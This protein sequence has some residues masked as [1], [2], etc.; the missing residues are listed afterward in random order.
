MASLKRDSSGNHVVCFR[1]GGREGAFVTVAGL[2][3]FL[4]DVR[5]RPL[6]ENERHE[7]EE[8]A[9]PVQPAAGS[10]RVKTC[11]RNGRS[12]RV[13]P[14][15]SSARMTSGRAATEEAAAGIPRDR[16]SVV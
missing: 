13:A 11:Q 3:V 8:I 7:R 1:V 4:I 16:K 2:L 5:R 6:T 9:P 14:A 12:S 10:N 15:T